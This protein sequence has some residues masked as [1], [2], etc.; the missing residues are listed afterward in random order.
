MKSIVLFSYSFIVSFIHSFIHSF[1]LSYIHTHT[2]KSRQCGASS[3]ARIATT[4]S[5]TPGCSTITPKPLQCPAA[6]QPVIQAAIC[7]P[8]KQLVSQSISQS[9]QSGSQPANQPASQPAIWAASQAI[10]LDARDEVVR[11]FHSSELCARR[12]PP[13]RV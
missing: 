8:V 4:R 5:T 1:I 7:Q 9:S 13:P 10:W 3:T 2:R 12:R 6:S 11:H